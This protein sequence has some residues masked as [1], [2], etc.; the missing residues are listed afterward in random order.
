MAYIDNTLQNYQAAAMGMSALSQANQ[1]YADRKKRKY[2]I[3]SRFGKD[4]PARYAMELELGKEDGWINKDNEN[5]Y[6]DYNTWKGSW[7]KRAMEKPEL[8][9]TNVNANATPEQTAAA[10]SSGV[11][12]SINPANVKEPGVVDLGIQK[13]DTDM[14]RSPF[15]ERSPYWVESQGRQKAATPAERELFQAFNEA[16]MADEIKKRRDAQMNRDVPDYMR[17]R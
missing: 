15:T 9:I 6:K 17:R 11:I 10:P 14:M 1:D 8:A 12:A 13:E 2:E 7:Q 5:D 3:L 16:K 4:D